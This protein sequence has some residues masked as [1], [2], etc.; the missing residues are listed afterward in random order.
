M[1]LEL[2]HILEKLDTEEGHD[3]RSHLPNHPPLLRQRLV[4]G[5][6]KKRASQQSAGASPLGSFKGN[7]NVTFM[8]HLV[9]VLIPCSFYVIMFYGCVNNLC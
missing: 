9:E 4:G 6:R 5:A 1:N 7:T 3:R 2:G 8:F